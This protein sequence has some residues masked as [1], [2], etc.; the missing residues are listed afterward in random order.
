MPKSIVA[1]IRTG[2]LFE[3]AA[4]AR[5]AASLAGELGL[6]LVLAHV[7][8]DPPVF[9]YGDRWS[10]EVRRRRL[11]QRGTDLLRAVAAEIGEP[12]AEKRIALS[13]FLRGG[14]AECLDAICRAERAELVVAGPPAV[15]TSH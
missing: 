2:E 15:D 11:H 9:P 7:A 4:P 5:V 10:R 1:G 14:P 13:G 8:N 12:T 6:R 3:V